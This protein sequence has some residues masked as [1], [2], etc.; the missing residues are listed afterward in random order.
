MSQRICSIEECSNSH[1]AR[2][3]C[4]KHYNRWRKTGDAT[5]TLTGRTVTARAVN[6]TPRPGA[7]RPRSPDVALGYKGAHKRVRAM[8]GKASAHPCASCGGRAAEW[9]YGHGDTS[10]EMTQTLHVFGKPP[11]AIAYSPNPDYYEPMCHPCH[12][13]GDMAKAKLATTSIAVTAN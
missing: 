8:R 7:R 12:V 1:F 3:W 11:R 9:A 10:S 6:V 4:E 5:Q 13:S 2:G